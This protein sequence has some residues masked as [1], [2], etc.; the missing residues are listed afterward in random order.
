MNVSRPGVR[1]VL[2]TVDTVGGVWTYALELARA[3]CRRGAHVTMATMGAPVNPRQRAQARSIAGLDIRASDFKLEWMDNPWADLERAADWLLRLEDEVAPDIVHLNGYAHGALPWRAPC[4][5]VGHSCVLSWWSAVKQ[6]PAPASW[7]RYR[8]VVRRGLH[9]AAAV[10]APSRAMLAE[11]NRHYGPLERTVVIP[12]GRDSSAFR[13]G[14][15]QP[16]ILSAGRVWDEAKNIALLGEIQPLV[17]WPIAV[18]GDDSHPNGGRRPVKNVRL[19]GV[20]PSRQLAHRYAR[21]AIYCLPAR[22]EPFGLSVL[23]AALSE[24]AL[25]LGDIPSLRETWDGAAHFAN[26]ADAAAFAASIESLIEDPSRRKELAAAARDRAS[27]YTPERMA[28]CYLDVYQ[29]ALA[30]RSSPVLAR[31]ET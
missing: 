8:E 31:T 17:S 29:G 6:E 25:V 19:L 27:Q 23:E 22:Y 12:N 10:I 4:V 18:A 2:M 1:R 3:L 7:S 20:I 9:A 15:K 30:H 14:V 21:A 28:E 5:V 24:C 26:P 16:V 13:G 11:L